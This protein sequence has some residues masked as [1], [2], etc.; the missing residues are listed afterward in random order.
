MQ[1]P[2]RQRAGGRPARRDLDPAALALLERHGAQILATAR[3]YAATPEDAEDAYQR[4]FEILLTKGPTA[5]EAELVPWLKTVVKHECFALRRQRERHSPVT[6]DGRLGDRPTPPAITHDQAER[7]ERLSQGAEALRQL[8]PQEIRA[9]RLKAEGYSY[10]EICEITGWTYTKVNRCLTE[11]R[12]AFAR[13]LA[14]I[15][16]GVECERFAPLLS[17]LADGEASAE[18][19]ALL[20]PHMRTCLACR[21]RL[22]AFRAVPARVAA[23]VPPA[24]LAIA[25]AGPLRRWLESIMVGTQQKM[26]AALGAT[27]QKAAAFGE[28]AH[29]LT[30]LAAGQ[31]VAAV[32]ASAVAVAGGGTAIE[33]FANHRGPPRAQ[34]EQREPERRAKPK[35]VKEE[36]PVSVAQAPAPMP[37][38]QPPAQTA[39]NPTPAPAPAPPPAA[40]PAPAQPVPPPPPDPATEFT[41][42]VVTSAAPA[43]AAAQPAPSANSNSG[44][45]GS[46]GEMSSGPGEFAP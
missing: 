6:D 19:L 18:D 3:R 7:Y 45:G 24:A 46:A 11:G 44:G 9:L 10:R 22:K 1:T 33:Q 35:P 26:E 30:E 28:R 42:G 20:R 43:P 37:D 14:G 41:P 38:P 12:Q 40:P 39:P 23:L 15:Q 36:V 27:Q 32:A 5:S 17:A 25:G 4:A 21:A 34:L 2:R 13:R 16:G 8:K 29:T 31:K